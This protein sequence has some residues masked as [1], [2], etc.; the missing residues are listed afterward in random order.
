[1][2]GKILWNILLAAPVALGAA[3]VGLTPAAIAVE[4]QTS[5]QTEA[6]STE[7][8][9]VTEVTLIEPTT[10][11]DELAP[12][13]LVTT[14][15]Q[16]VTLP[17]VSEVDAV[18]ESEALGVSQLA[19]LQEYSAEG[20]GEEQEA[21]QV[22]S[23]SQLSD[24]QPTD[25]AFQALQSLVE[26]YGCIAGYPDGTY[27]GNRAL[28]R[29]EFAAGMNACLDRITE[30]ISSGSEGVVTREDLATLQRLQEE[31][32]AELATI[33]GL[34]DNLEARTAELEANQF[35]TTTRLAGETIFAI[36]DI[37]GGEADADAD[38]EL[39]EPGVDEQNNLVFQSRVRLNFDTSF[40]G[41]DRLR[42]RL[43]GGNFSRFLGD[44][45]AGET[46]LG[47]ETNTSSYDVRVDDLNYQ[48]NLGDRTRIG[49]FANS[50]D[51][52]DIVLE[53]VASPFV[54]SGRGAISRFG[55]FNPIYRITNANGAASITYRLTN[56]A[57]TNN[58]FSVQLGYGAGEANNP[59]QGDGLFSG[60]Y[61]AIA[62]LVGRNLLGGNLDLVFT[63]INSYIGTEDDP[64]NPDP[65]DNDI[66]GIRSPGLGSRLS[67]VDRDRPLSVNS[68]GLQANYR[69]S[70]G[71]QLG[72][73]VGYSFVRAIGLG[74]ADVLNY[75]VTL[76]F[77]DLL[78]EGNLGGIVFG[79]QPRLIDS[80]NSLG[81]GD[82]GEDLSTGFHIE[83]FYR[84]AVTDNI[85]ITPGIIWLTAPNHNEDND[86]IFVGTI[87]T[88][89]RF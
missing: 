58:V 78:G 30:L 34:V 86:D 37:F 48:F 39:E 89:F 59:D 44:P 42:A 88:T 29:Y 67:R 12:V 41:T 38:N 87:R 60:D 6:A 13:P 54:S 5:S 17:V 31:F 35:S 69:F 26:R 27:R 50:A 22:T 52:R 43:Q 76:A 82:D 65:D 77:P 55:R 66:A 2:T 7:L 3:L 10:Q 15:T 8:V 73:W 56:P 62:Q 4:A 61:S 71:F 68:Y 85:D 53:N 36:S 23:V 18:A 45:S 19:Q 33:R 20:Q 24:V 72:G 11:V 16:A 84:L 70:P 49:I 81:L 57:L 47:F 32:A 21:A 83:G 51:L 9:S 28:T 46:R 79:M 40:T 74:D 63:Y 64:A 14:E 25:W 75:A 80:D 1:M